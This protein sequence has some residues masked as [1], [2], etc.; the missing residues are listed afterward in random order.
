MSGPGQT[1]YIVDDDEAVRDALRMLFDAAGLCAETFASA[2][3]FLKDYRPAQAECLVLDVRMP[4]MSG[5]ALQEEMHKRRMRIPIVF[6]TGHAD[7]PIAVRALKKGAFDFIEKP[8]DSQRLVVSVMNAL[9]FDA[10]QR[11]QPVP[12]AAEPDPAAARLALLSEREREV[13]DLV[14]KGRQTRAI[15]EELC[16]SVKTVEFHRARIREKLDVGSLA[17]LFRLFLSR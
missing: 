6:L 3:A 5:L 16:I 10:E 4:G 1:V 2:A 14:L 9:R 8:L 13:L 17:E 12:Q 7:V 15:A 11:M